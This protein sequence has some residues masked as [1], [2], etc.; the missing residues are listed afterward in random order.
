[1]FGTGELGRKVSKAE[2]EK[3]EP[4]VRLGL[5]QAQDQLKEGTFPV[6]VLIGG[7]EGAGKGETVN[8][9]HEW[10]DPRHIRTAAFGERTEE[11][12][13][14]PRMWR[15]WMALPAR[16]QIGILFHSWY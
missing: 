10:M 8:K 3:R 1:M 13:E 16:G 14:R 11:E 15:Y 6:I 4:S 7:V 5:L 12:R 2:Y 9:L